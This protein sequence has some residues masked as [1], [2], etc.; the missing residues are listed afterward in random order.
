M[1]VFTQRTLRETDYA[2]CRQMLLDI[3][4]ET[5]LRQFVE[6]WGARSETASFAVQ[7]ADSVSSLSDKTEQSSAHVCVPRDKVA[8]YILVD[9]HHK[10]EYLCVDPVYRNARLGSTLL[11]TALDRLRAEGARDIT[12]T[13][14]KDARL[15]DWYAKF[16]FTIVRNLYDATGEFAGAD[17]RLAVE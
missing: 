17:M 5:E 9:I 2:I 13:T 11:M 15:T 8:G 16:G 6:A 1:S 3:F 12:L 4:G 10:I 14:A 7:V